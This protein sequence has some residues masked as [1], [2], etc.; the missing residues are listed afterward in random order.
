MKKALFVLGILVAL[1][2]PTYAAQAG[3]YCQPASSYCQGSYQN[4]NT[5]LS[6][7]YYC[8]GDYCTPRRGCGGYC[9]R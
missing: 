4:Q 7:G 6:S 3:V 9:G 1:A 5:N 2:A 8:D